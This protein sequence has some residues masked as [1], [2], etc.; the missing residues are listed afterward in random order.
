MGDHQITH[1]AGGGNRVCGRMVW[2]ASGSS[3]AG[4]VGDRCVGVGVG[5][6]GSCMT[7]VLDVVGASIAGTG[8]MFQ[9]CMG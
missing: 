5:G 7:G 4:W 6:S 8:A 1:L 2:S 3:G 9:R